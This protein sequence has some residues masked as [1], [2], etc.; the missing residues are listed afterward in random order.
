[1]KSMLKVLFCLVFFNI[2]GCSQSSH[3]FDL[4]K[5][6]YNTFFKDIN[7]ITIDKTIEQEHHRVIVD[8]EDLNIIKEEMKIISNIREVSI[9]VFIGSKKGFHALFIDKRHTKPENFLTVLYSIEEQMM[10]V[11]KCDVYPQIKVDFPNIEVYEFKMPEKV[12]I[13]LEKYEQMLPEEG[14]FFIT[15]PFDY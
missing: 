5:S 9:D 12:S 4:S 15:W 13:I 11:R 10:I 3:E 14:R 8:G 7:I 6:I 1:M 2:L